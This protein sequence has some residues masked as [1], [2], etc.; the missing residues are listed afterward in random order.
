MAVKSQSQGRMTC[1]DSRI[2]LT[3]LSAVMSRFFDFCVAQIV[4]L[5]K[6][7]MIQIQQRGAR[8]KVSLF[9][10]SLTYL[11]KIYFLQR[12]YSLSE[13]SA[14]PNIC[15]DKSKTHFVFGTSRFGDPTPH[16]RRLLEEQ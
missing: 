7:H 15:R 10:L 11:L 5:I 13:D 14:N 4:E 6:G 16:G 1:A 8:P 12:T 9:P 3:C 2:Y